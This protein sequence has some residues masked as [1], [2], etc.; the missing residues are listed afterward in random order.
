[1]PATK[2]EIRTD[3]GVCPAHVLHPDGAGPWPGVLVYMDGIG[4]RPAIVAI[5]ER[6]AAGGYYVL[7]PDLFYRAGAYVPPD[8]KKVFTDEATRAEWRKLMATAGGAANIMRDT[9]AYLAHFAGNPSVRQPRIG[10]TGYCMGGRMAL[11]AAG[12]YPDRFAGVA[13]FHPGG[14]AT[15]APDSPHLLAPK[16]KARVY[17]AGAEDD[18]SFPVEQKQRLEAA[19]TAAGVAHRIETYPARHGWVPSDMPVHDAAQAERHWKALFD[20]FA[21]TLPRG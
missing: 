2:I 21:A 8:P 4:M 5:G 6:L 11:E 3:D 16:M 7:L 12:Q 1:M 9:A 17:V 14:L 15:D 20:L 13:A 18:S 10:A 19:L